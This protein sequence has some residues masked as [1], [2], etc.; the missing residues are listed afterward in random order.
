MNFQ[1]KITAKLI[2]TVSWN[3]LFCNFWDLN[4]QFIFYKLYYCQLKNGGTVI[5]IYRDHEIIEE[6]GNF[7]VPILNRYYRSLAEAQ[8]AIDD[9]LKR[10]NQSRS[11]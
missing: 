4:W 9:Y 3:F 11:R 10:R 8:R 2:I 6:N 5:P 7:Y 1:K